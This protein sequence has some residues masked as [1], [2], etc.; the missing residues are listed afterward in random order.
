MLK[1][2]KHQIGWV[3]RKYTTIYVFKVK[4]Y[5][6]QMGITGIIRRQIK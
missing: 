6:P 5:A 1:N 2:M 3:Y 4:W